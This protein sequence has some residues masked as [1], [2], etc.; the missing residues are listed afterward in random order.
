EY[1]APSEIKYIDVV[2]TYDLE[3]EASKVVPHGGFNYI[4]G[5]SG[6]EWTKRANDRA[7]KHK[8]LYPRLAQDVEAPDTS[9]EILGHKIK[10]P[11]IMAPIAAHGLAHTTKE[12]GTARAVSEFGTIMSISAYSGATFEEISEG[13]NGGPRWFQ[14]YM[15]KDDQQNR[16]ILDEAKSDGATAI[17]LTADSTNRDYPFGMPIVQRYLRGT[18]EGMY[19]ASKQ[20]ISPR[21]IEEIAAHSGLPVF[22]KGIQH[23]E[24]ADMAI[25]RGASGIW[26]SNHGA[27]QLYEAPGS[28]DTLPAIAE[29]VNKR[30]PI[31]FDSGVRRGEHVAKA[32]ASGA[33]VVALGRP[34][35][36][37]LALGGWQGAYS[38]LDYFQKDLTRVMQLTGSQNVEDLKGL[39]LFDNPYG[40]EYEYNAP[41][42]IK[43]IDVVNTYD[44]EE[45]ASKV[46][47]HGGFNYIAGAS[48]DEWTK[49]ANDRAW[50]H[51]LLYPRLAQDVEAPDTSTEILGHKIK[52][53]FI[54]APIAAHGLAHTTKEAG[55]ARAVSEFGTI[56]SIS[57]YSGAT[58]EEIS[59]G[60]NGGPRWFQIYMAKDDQQNRD[61]LDEAKS[62]GATAIILTADS[63][64]SG[65]RDRDVKNKFVYPF[66]MP[67]VQRYLRGTAEGMSLN[68]IYGASKQKISPRD[69]EEIAAHS[70]LP[71]F[72]KGIQHPEDADMAIKRGASGIWVSN[73][74]ARQLYEAPGSFDTLPAIAERV[75][76]RVPI[77]FDSGVRRGEHVAKALASGADVV[78]LG[79]PVLFG[80]ALGGWQGAYSVLDY[81]QK[82]LTRVMQL[83]GS[84]NVEDLKG[85][86]LFDNPYG[87][88]Y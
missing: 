81:F 21:D 35:L 51:K 11:F 85:L 77:V 34:V 5:A 73:H 20:K 8:L 63:T 68:N 56:M 42:E 88:E 43:Y 44:L 17:I 74:G 14:I 72:V 45:E 13:L 2:N 46:V 27:R 25:K 59:E 65:N 37:G 24:D 15:A 52:A 79:R 76:K 70:G 32:L 60:L 71:V 40:Y 33:D 10:A 61:I 41:S 4:A 86:D 22:V 53:P 47:P 19:G 69:I 36:F 58:F 9:T 83:T 3:E 87:Y 80:L 30:V 38:V 39:D 28:F 66:G 67:I 6:D 62:D 12:A 23:P 49:R 31:V 57:A 64:V 26:V 82:D 16:D 29:R 55:T 48:G 54:M 50:K 18:A 75:N 78:A 1:N 84:Q 7:W